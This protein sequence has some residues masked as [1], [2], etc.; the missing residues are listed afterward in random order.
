MSP[1][2]TPSSIRCRPVQATRRRTPR[3]RHRPQLMWALAR[4][5][6]RRASRVGVPTRGRTTRPTMRRSRTGPR[7][8]RRS[9]AR[10]SCLR[11][12]R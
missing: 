9:S 6:I 2:L 10:S 7:P 3:T 5:S 8:P 4:S 11:R 12:R 1:Q